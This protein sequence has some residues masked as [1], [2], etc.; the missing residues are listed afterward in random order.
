MHPCGVPPWKIF[1]LT[2]STSTASHSPI[3][4]AL[5]AAP[6]GEDH[7]LPRRVLDYVRGGQLDEELW[8]TWRFFARHPGSP[9]WI[10]GLT[11]RPELNGSHATVSGS[12]ETG[13]DS[14]D[15][16]TTSIVVRLGSDPDAGERVLISTRKLLWC[17]PTDPKDVDADAI[18]QVLAKDMGIEA[19]KI[20]CKN[21]SCKRC[22]RPCEAGKHCKVPHPPSRRLRLGKPGRLEDRVHYLCAA[23]GRLQW[24]SR[25]ASAVESAGMCWEGKHMVA[26]CS[27]LDMKVD[28]RI[29]CTQSATLHVW[30][31]GPPPL[32]VQEEMDLLPNSVTSLG[33]CGYD[34]DTNM[35][36]YHN[37]AHCSPL[38]YQWDA[39][40]SRIKLIHSLPNLEKLIISDVALSELVVTGER[41]P[42][43]K[44]LSLDHIL[45][46]FDCR[47]HFS[48]S[49]LKILYINY[50]DEHA[51]AIENA[52]HGA[53]ALEELHISELYEVSDLVIAS[54]T[55]RS[56][57]LCASGYGNNNE[58]AV[59]APN[60]KELFAAPFILHQDLRW[61]KNHRLELDLPA[62]HVRPPLLVNNQSM[63][64]FN[65][66]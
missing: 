32:H 13:G 35:E 11:H 49:S 55:L 47:Y 42:R 50:F 25:G 23:C 19:A 48:T 2:S 18:A 36:E 45:N 10:T 3:A 60:L 57:S 56:L 28:Q 44:C 17:P 62:G 15:V 59:W 37:Y 40:E 51:V 64:T 1:L 26:A 53:T 30:N 16:D 4:R 9:V 38:P 27:D 63:W 46:D 33:I 24:K 65:L 22:Q 29:F 31:K 66:G 54:N 41:F 20:V 14:F 39:A 12:C 8:A 52:L 21:M 43:L 61:L 34:Y 7:N 5:A 6:F 58:I